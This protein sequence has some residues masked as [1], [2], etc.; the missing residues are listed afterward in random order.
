MQNQAF[1]EAFQ[2]QTLSQTLSDVLATSLNDHNVNMFREP[3]NFDR[4]NTAAGSFEA[5]FYSQYQVPSFPLG[6]SSLAPLPLPI[7]RPAN[8]F[9]PSTAWNNSDDYLLAAVAAEQ[10]RLAEV[11]AALIG[12]H[13][14]A[15]HEPQENYSLLRRQQQHRDSYLTFVQ[16]A[17][18]M[19]TMAP[20]A[21]PSSE[22]VP[23]V[24]STKVFEV[25]GSNLRGKSDPYLDVSE[26][27]VIPGRER[28]TIRGGVTEPFP[29][30]LYCMLEDVEKQ[31]KSHIISFYC[32][33]R[34]FAIHDMK[35]FTDEILPNYF[36]KQAKLFSFVR[37][38]NLYGFVRI[39]SGTDLGGY[40]HELFLKGRPELLPYMRRTGAPKG[41]EDR[42]KSKD[43]H[44]L[45]IQLDFYAMKPIRP[46]KP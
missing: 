30:K 32:H 1:D 34:A 46:R 9:N 10:R 14:M 19:Q 33:G 38:L 31:G 40:Y 4:R 12:K 3:A 41:K 16:S 15:T 17:Q 29:Q 5:P 26:L 7:P 42:R 6:F 20:S 11:Q 23:F 37:Q 36:A 44:T 18:P 35:A 45:A 25:L 39:H 8:Y 22:A 21:P 2:R 13:Q 43:R 28:K 27:P 24:D